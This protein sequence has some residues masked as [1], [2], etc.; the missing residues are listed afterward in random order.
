LPQPQQGEQATPLLDLTDDIHH[1]EVAAMEER[2][3]C[4]ERAMAVLAV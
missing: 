2:M 3:D 1:I 4:I